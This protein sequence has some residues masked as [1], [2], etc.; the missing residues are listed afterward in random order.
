MLG[1][2]FAAS[3]SAL[4]DASI[5]VHPGD[6]G[7]ANTRDIEAVLQSVAGV[8]LPDF[9]RHRSASIEVRSSAAGPRVLASRSADGGYQVLLNV[10]GARWDQFAYQFSHELCHIVSEFDRREVAAPGLR[11]YQWFEETI[12]EAVS[13]VTLNRLASSWRR[14]PP[15][16]AWASYAPAFARYAER[17]VASEHRRLPAGKSLLAW[18]RENEHGLESDPYL[19]E[20]NEAAAMALIELLEG[21]PGSLAAIAYLNESR[22]P[23]TFAAY[24]AAWRDCCPE[25]QRAFVR[26]LIALFTEA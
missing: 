8:L 21:E 10:Q 4:A 23:A 13:L 5:R 17:L 6:W 1:A 19:R 15:R 12:C 2:A 9:P 14:S 26:Q 11:S 24:L 25:P 22:A 16:A 18:Y 20:K 7:G 3:G